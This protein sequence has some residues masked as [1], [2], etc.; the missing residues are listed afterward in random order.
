TINGDR[1][2]IEDYNAIKPDDFNRMPS[3]SSPTDA[4]IYETSI[5]DF[6]SDPN[7]G[8]KDKGKYLG[9]IESGV[10]PDGQVT[11]L[12]YLKSLGITHVQIMPMFD[13]ASID[14]TKNDG[15]YNWGY[16]PKNYNVP[17]GSY[18]SNAADPTARIMEMKEMINGL[19]KAGIRVIMDV[20][21]NHVYSPNDQA[22]QKTV[23]GYYLDR[24]S[25]V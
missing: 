5:R 18:S 10:T 17:E 9:M 25:V 22:L 23:P 21:Y 3:F 12:D 4:I 2:V 1:S 19:H 11:G 15:T 20:V 16:D 7:S 14:E 8:I 13:F 6:T 24:K